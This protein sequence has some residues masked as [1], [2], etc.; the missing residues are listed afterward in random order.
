MIISTLSGIALH[1][2]LFDLT[3]Y[4]S[5]DLFC[6]LWT[7]DCGHPYL[8]YSH[9][10]H[11]IRVD[12]NVDMGKDYFREKRKGTRKNKIDCSPGLLEAPSDPS[13]SI[14]LLSYSFFIHY[15]RF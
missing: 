11:S 13:S 2:S 4:E 5:M 14:N 10:Y 1:A 3:V 9:L 12:F 6:R 8:V 15:P 7:V